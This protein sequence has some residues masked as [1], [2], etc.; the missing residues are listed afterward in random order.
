VIPVDGSSALNDIQFLH[1]QTKVLDDNQNQVR[2]L[3]SQFELINRTTT[4]FQNLTLHA[5]DIPS[6]TLA[7]TGIANMVDSAGNNISNAAQARALKPTHGMQSLKFG[8][9]VNPNAADL[10]L[11]TSSEVDQSTAGQLGIKQQAVTQGILQNT[12]TVL[13]YGFA[14]RGFSSGSYPVPQRFIAARNVTN[15]CGI[16]TCKGLITLAYALPKVTTDTADLNGFDA[17]FI[18]ANQTDGMV[19]QSIEEQLSGT[20][21]GLKADASGNASTVA[22][23]RTLAG[24]NVGLGFNVVGDKLNP[25]CQVRTAVGPNVFLGKEPVATAGSLD[26]CFGA[27]GGLRGGLGKSFALQADGKIVMAGETFQAGFMV[28]RYR[29]NGAL[30]TDFGMKGRVESN[31]GSGELKLNALMVADGKIIA[32]GDTWRNNNGIVAL[33][34]FNPDGS[35]DTSFDSDGKALTEFTSRRARA[36]DAVLQPDGKIVVVGKLESD[37]SNIATAGDLLLLRYNTDGSLDT[38]F[39]ADGKVVADFGFP[40]SSFPSDE[41]ANAVALQK[42]GTIVVAGFVNTSGTY[43]K[44]TQFQY[45]SNGVLKGRSTIDINAEYTYAQD[46]VVQSDAKIVMVG[47]SKNHNSGFNQVA[48]VARLNADGQRDSAFGAD[49][50]VITAFDFG[51]GQIHAAAIQQDGKILATGYT[52]KPKPGGGFVLNLTVFRYNLNGSLDAAFGSGGRVLADLGL[53]GE[54]PNDMVVQKDGKILI[55]ATYFSSSEI[56]ARFH[57]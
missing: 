44:M 10:Q 50:V 4:D 29:S 47:Y 41:G 27:S 54:I 16:D 32:L 34:R 38:S 28:T 55:S 46:I 17:Y 57:P 23:I 1:R 39:G 15:D 42:D 51:F 22:Q 2:Y 56:L 30:D 26:I 19:A 52:N 53:V 8:E 49:G 6:V 37:S 20:V 43:G 13:E 14:A 5:V 45:R 12:A 9:E 3:S 21:A 18:V 25:L 24:S 40:G 35:L 31:V 11:F 48:A 33:V 7:G 36:N